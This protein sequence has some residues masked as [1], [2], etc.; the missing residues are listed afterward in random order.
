MNKRFSTL[1]AAFAALTVVSTA[2]VKYVQLTNPAGREALSWSKDVPTVDSVKMKAVNTLT[3]K[4]LNDSA[5]WDVKIIRIETGGDTVCTFTN[6]A[7]NKLLSFAKSAS[8]TAKIAEGVTEFVF[9]E[10][11][12]IYAY[13]GDGKIIA[14]SDAAGALA[15]DVASATALKITDAPEIRLTTTK[16]LTGNATT[17][18]FS[19]GDKDGGIFTATELIPTSVPGAV[20]GEDKFKFQ[21]V[22][23]ENSAA[24]TKPAQYIT[25]DTA[26]YAGSVKAPKF[27][28]DTLVAAGDARY[29]GVSNAGLQSFNVFMNLSN[30]SIYL[31]TDTV[32]VFDNATGAYS[33]VDHGGNTA[34]KYL[35]GYKTLA[36]STE[37]LT[38]DSVQIVAPFITFVKGDPVKLATGEGVYSLKFIGT[39]GNSTGNGKYLVFAN[40]AYEY[41]ADEATPYAAYTQA[42]VKDNGDG[43]YSIQSRETKTVDPQV[44]TNG[45]TYGDA[46]PAS[47]LLDKKV[48]YSVK[49]AAAGVYAFENGA[50]VDT[51]LFTKLDVNAADKS[52]GYK[53]FTKEEMGYG[54]V[55]FKLVSKATDDVYLSTTQD[56]IVAGAKTAF[57]DALQMRLTSDIA[58]DGICDTVYYG[59]QELGDTLMRV[60]YAMERP[61]NAKSKFYATDANLVKM[62]VDAD[63]TQ[64]YFFVSGING[65]GYQIVKS[66]IETVNPDSAIIMNATYLTVAY[67]ELVAGKETFFKIEG[68]DAPT[69]AKLPLGHY[70]IYKGYDM[71]TNNNGVAKFMRESDELKAGLDADDFALY[72]DSAY[73]DRGADN[74]NYGYYIYKGANVD[75]DT[76]VGTA[77]TVGKTNGYNEAGIVA[78]SALFVATRVVKDSIWYANTAANAPIQVTNA[79]NRSVMMFK[80]VGDSYVI[81]P[82]NVANR[83][84][85]VVND[86][87]L[88]AAPNMVV[89]QPITFEAAETPTSNEAI[90]ANTIKVAA[91]VGNVT[92][93]GAAGKKIIVSDVVGRTTTVVATSD[94]E[95]I[96]ATSGVVIVKVEGEV[97]KAVV[98]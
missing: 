51:V 34:D 90:D 50:G 30:D 85:A 8:A 59:A 91:G 47:L 5:L 58:K 21:V 3:T 79:A 38:I 76:I 23:S 40:G 78:D 80:V 15:S 9:K 45:Q 74:T 37:V 62:A 75:N 86:V 63:S 96:P 27:Q 53:F 70:N 46:T 65:E 28:L 66:N 39:G 82:M 1:L 73:V 35:V 67:N 48:L 84:L 16:D 98:E 29:K 88:F 77:L 22:G 32:V 83:F 14:Y 60:S 6:K 57:D 56:S 19:F 61:Y 43:T 97:V 25:V 18:Q 92:V 49:N 4:A 69:Y 89:A 10:D 93:Y 94:A 71:L 26:S 44:G 42:F 52:V 55:A 87:V 2:Q 13:I 36:N 20:S 12:A 72:I 11:V 41:S 33:I 68:G 64:R 81:T 54:A 31:T 24:G 7:T 95:T 17:F